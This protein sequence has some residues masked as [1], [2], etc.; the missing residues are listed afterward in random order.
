[1]AQRKRIQIGTM[2]L[3]VESLALLSGLRIRH[4]CGCGVE[5]AATAQIR[6][7]AWEPP[8]AVEVAPEKAKRQ[9]TKNKN[10]NKTL[11]IFCPLIELFLFL[12]L[13]FECSLCILDVSPLSCVWLTNIFSN[14]VAYCLFFLTRSLKSKSFKC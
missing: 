11:Y 14:S 8:Y 13:S 4:C 3:W 1:M 12:L 7:L 9:K 2:R 5:P 6:P 10:K